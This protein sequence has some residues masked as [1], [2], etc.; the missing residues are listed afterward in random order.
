MRKKRRSS[1]A[2]INHSCAC[3]EIWSNNDVYSACPK[4]CNFNR[5]DWDEEKTECIREECYCDDEEE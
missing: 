3:G 1:M 2:C 5:G 4:C